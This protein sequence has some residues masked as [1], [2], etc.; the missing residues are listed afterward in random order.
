MNFPWKCE[1]TQSRRNHKN[2]IASHSDTLWIAGEK[3]ARKIPAVRGCSEGESLCL[4]LAWP[5]IKSNTLTDSIHL[6]FGKQTKRNLITKSNSPYLLKMTIWKIQC[7]F[8]HLLP[9]LNNCS[10]SEKVEHSRKIKL[11]FPFWCNLPW[12]EKR[13]R[14]IKWCNVVDFRLLNEFACCRL[15]FQFNLTRQSDL[16]LLT[17]NS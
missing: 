11:F 5:H 8:F 2:K 4:W 3:G 15:N 10:W 6:S 13:G 7:R 12:R 14:E 16:N 17:L 1:G 9:A